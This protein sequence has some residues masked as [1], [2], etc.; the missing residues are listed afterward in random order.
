MPP[1]LLV[2]A[3]GM[4]SRYG[5]L[6]QLD[7]VG[8]SGETI[9]DYSVFDALEAG[10]GRV[11]FVI[12]K[13]FEAEFRGRVGDT[14]GRHVEVD[15]AFQGID[16]LPDGFSAP[17][18]RSKPW[19]TAH[20]IWCARE[21]VTGPFAAINAD[22]FYGAGAF[23][24]L[25][26]FFVDPKPVA[27]PEHFAMVGF[28]LARTLSEHGTVSRGVC[29]LDGS[30]DLLGVEEFT[31]IGRESEGLVQRG[32]DGRV[33]HFRGDEIVSMNFWGF[34]PAVFP[35]L[36]EGFGEFLRARGR[37]EKSEY[38]IPSAVAAMIGGGEARVS[39]LP[40]DS[41]WFGITYREDKPA[42]MASIAR[43]VAA[44]VYPEKLWDHA[45]VAG[46]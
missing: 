33:T 30:G 16:A 29:T 35:L 5:G 32:A 36:G 27:G 8:P 41:E 43:L 31:G 15:Y 4:G 3:A 25:A 46:S 11:V 28:R 37:E 21:R 17:P 10:F 39:V 42:V 2:L 12:R 23:R 45:G 26:D 44:G 7:P 14:Y 9:L 24:A 13:D 19:G 22:D 6:K 18:G 38:Y 1:T 20:A 34:T 40:T